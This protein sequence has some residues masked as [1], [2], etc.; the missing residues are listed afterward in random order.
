MYSRKRENKD[1]YLSLSTNQQISN[2]QPDCVK[3][4]VM[5]DG[6]RP[7]NQ[8]SSFKKRKSF[9]NLFTKVPI[10]YCFF[11]TQISNRSKDFNSTSRNHITLPLPQEQDSYP[12]QRSMRPYLALC[13]RKPNYLHC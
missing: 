1:M 2:Q 8:I 12:F 6:R 3:S 9:L 7:L 10:F 5:T 11:T 4:N 13:S